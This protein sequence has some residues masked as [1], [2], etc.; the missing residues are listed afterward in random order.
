MEDG[1]RLG[2]SRCLPN[3]LCVPEGTAV[4]P[5]ADGGEGTAPTLAGMLVPIATCMRASIDAIIRG[6]ELAMAVCTD[7]S[8]IDWK[9]EIPAAG[10]D[11][12]EWVAL[13]VGGPRTV[14][15]TVAG[16]LRVGGVPPGDEDGAVPLAALLIMLP[17]SL[18]SG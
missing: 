17:L 9:E 14:A 3:E 5:G 1:E 10:G 16:G 4:V 18:S 15:I 11:E 7:W 13:L 6:I 12:V 8:S 2:Y